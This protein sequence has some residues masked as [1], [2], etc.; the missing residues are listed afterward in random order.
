MKYVH[1]S[2]RIVSTIWSGQSRT[3]AS[4]RFL[5][6]R[7]VTPPIRR[8]FIH[9][10]IGTD[11]Q[12]TPGGNS[13]TVT[14]RN[15]A[16][17]FFFDPVADV[18]RLQYL[19]CSNITLTPKL[20]SSRR[21]YGANI[22]D[23]GVNQSATPAIG[24]RIF[25]VSSGRVETLRHQVDAKYSGNRNDAFNRRTMRLT[26]SYCPWTPEAITLLG[27][28]SDAQ[29]ARNLGIASPSVVIK[30]QKLGIPPFRPQKLKWTREMLACLGK[31]SDHELSERFKI[32][33][34][35]VQRKRCALG[36]PIIGQAS[37]VSRPEN[38]SRHD[39]GSGAGLGSQHSVNRVAAAPQSCI[40]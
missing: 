29:L 38:G 15:N 9:L 12:I 34:T 21:C 6:I 30:R 31:M 10:V 32:G 20:G 13:I 11:V 26:E 27:K 3:V 5:R 7:R 2:Y 25:P 37:R 36:N 39:D 4:G 40:R 16:Q 19:N 18:L 1:L 24:T 8:A 23:H 28:I 22:C 33:K 17:G 14:N 35:S